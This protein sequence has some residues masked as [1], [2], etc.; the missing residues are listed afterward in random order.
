MAGGIGTRFWPMST[1]KLPKQ[2][3][4]ILGTG[5]TLIQQTFKRLSRIVPKE[6]IYVITNQDYKKITKEQLSDI[7]TDNIIAEPAMMNT[8]ACNIYIAKKIYTKNPNASFIVAPS[9]HIIL[10]EDKFAETTEIALQYASE[11]NYLITLGIQPTRPDTG[12]GY[13][14][15]LDDSD[16]E[17]KKVK[18]FTEKPNDELA[19]VFLNSGDFLWNAGIFI[20][21]AKAILKA[22]NEH[23]HEMYFAFDSIKTYNTKQEEKDIEKV[24]FTVSKTSIDY[25]IM[26]KAENVYVIPSDFGWS[27]LGTWKSLYENS[28]KNSEE[29]AIYGKYVHVYDSENNII[30]ST[31]DKAIVIDGLKNYIVVDTPK[32]L[33]ICPIDKE[34][35]V[36]DYVNDLKINKGEH[37]L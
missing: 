7:P 34:Q 24:Y 22:F 8:A 3:H 11:N 31:E 30:K 21:N 16:S 9:D 13:I 10:N 25:A 26:E 27:D 4:D 17:L 32:A 14:Q 15:Y 5:N 1:S 23:M 20:W 28:E 33:L 36:K 6:N 19:K 35:S 18:T 29:N 12:Y 37:F 2:Y